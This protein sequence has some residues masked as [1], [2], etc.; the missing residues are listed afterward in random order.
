MVSLVPENN[1]R[2]QR[3][4]KA[5][6]LTVFAYTQQCEPEDKVAFAAIRLYIE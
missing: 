2:P 5:V 4:I 1:L 3:K 6:R